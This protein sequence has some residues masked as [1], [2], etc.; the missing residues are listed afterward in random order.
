MGGILQHHADLS[1]SR[2]WPS[3]E[4]QN[5]ERCVAIQYDRTAEIKTVYNIR[6]HLFMKQTKTIDH[7]PSTADAFG[8]YVKR[9]CFPTERVWSQARVTNPDPPSPLNWGWMTTGTS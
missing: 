3:L 9:A 2:S 6:R 4:P 8:E 7:I 5:T 1:C